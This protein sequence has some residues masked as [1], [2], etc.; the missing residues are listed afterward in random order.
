MGVLLAESH[1]KV[2][3][4][5]ALAGLF[6]ALSLFFYG[7]VFPGTVALISAA[8]GGVALLLFGGAIPE[9]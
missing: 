4:F 5:Y 7:M 3:V 8:G 9:E 6:L 1:E 2:A